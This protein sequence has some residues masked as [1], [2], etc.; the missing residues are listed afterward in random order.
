MNTKEIIS[1]IF[2]IFKTKKINFKLQLKLEKKSCTD[3]NALVKLNLLQFLLDTTKKTLYIYD[4]NDL[5][6]IK[7]RVDNID[8]INKN[9]LLFENVIKREKILDIDLIKEIEPFFDS[10]IGTR[11]IYIISIYNK[12][13]LPNIKLLLF[14]GFLIGEKK[15][16]IKENYK[17]NI[18]GLFKL[19][20]SKIDFSFI[21]SNAYIY[22]L[23]EG[24]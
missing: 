11:M 4:I 18:K 10:S 24:M 1:K 16:F 23:N 8:L 14:L 17:K 21:D 7:E 2:T 22:S 15:D 13:N 5:W 12:F 20:G 9:I 19:I 3:D 6:F